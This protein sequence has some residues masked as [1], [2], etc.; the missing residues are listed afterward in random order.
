M[1]DYL[2]MLLPMVGC[3]EFLGFNHKNIGMYVMCFQIGWVL[4]LPIAQPT[5]VE[6]SLSLLLYYFL[7]N[8]R[9][10]QMGGS[11]E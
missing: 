3:E 2:A 7:D 10:R 11:I 9:L 4:K 1:Q 5:S 6:E 8:R